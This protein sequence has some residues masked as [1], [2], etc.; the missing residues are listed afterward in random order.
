MPREKEK[1]FMK[2]LGEKQLDLLEL[3]LLLFH[4]IIKRGR[5]N[6]KLKIDHESMPK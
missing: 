3:G 5:N 4:Q 1:R 2:I 6:L